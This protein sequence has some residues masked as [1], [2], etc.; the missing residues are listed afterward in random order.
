MQG[1]L[2]S[3]LLAS[4][5]LS[6][7][8]E[9][10]LLLFYIVFEKRRVKDQLLYIVLA[11]VFSF[12]S[13]TVCFAENISE[14]TGIPIKLF[15]LTVA[16]E[17]LS[18][19]QSDLQSA[20]T[21][22]SRAGFGFI[23]AETIVSVFLAFKGGTR[24]LKLLRIL[25]FVNNVVYIPIFL[26][27][28]ALFFVTTLLFLIEAAM[29][30][31]VPLCLIGTACLLPFRRARKVGLVCLGFLLVFGY[32]LPYCV[33]SALVKAPRVP[34]LDY[35]EDWGVVLF[36]VV[37]ES[38]DPVPYAL[39][40]LEF[41][42]PK[43]ESGMFVV[44]MNEYGKRLAILPH[45]VY[46]VKSVI[47]LW[48]NISDYSVSYCRGVALANYS[49]GSK[50][51]P[52]YGKLGEFSLEKGGYS[53]GVYSYKGDL[54]EVKITLRDFDWLVNETGVY[55]FSKAFVDHSEV[56]PL[57]LGDRILYK[58]VLEPGENMTVFFFGGRV[59]VRYEA[60]NPNMSVVYRT[61]LSDSVFNCSIVGENFFKFLY[62]EFSKWWNR[63][64]LDFIMR[65]CRNFSDFQDIAEFLNE[66][67]PRYF[68]YSPP[69]GVCKIWVGVHGNISRGDYCTVWVEVKPFKQWNYTT[70]Y[71]YN[72]YWS[73]YEGAYE[74]ERGFIGMIA[75]VFNLVKTMFYD[76]IW[77]S[78]AVFG[79]L[80]IGVAFDVLS[81]VFLSFPFFR[82]SGVSSS[83][84]RVG[85]RAFRF[86]KKKFFSK[87][88]REL[89]YLSKKMYG[90]KYS[91][92]PLKYRYLVL[93]KY[94][95]LKTGRRSLVK[96]VAFATVYGSEVLRYRSRVGLYRIVA[97]LAKSRRLERIVDELEKYPWGVRE[98]LLEKIG[99]KLRDVYDRARVEVAVRRLLKNPSARVSLDRRLVLLAQASL[100]LPRLIEVYGRYLRREVDDGEVLRVA[101][102]MVLSGEELARGCLRDPRA[103][104]LAVSAL[105]SF[106]V[107]SD[108]IERLPFMLDEKKIGLSEAREYALSFLNQVAFSRYLKTGRFEYDE[109]YRLEGRE[110]VE[111]VAE[112]AR[113]ESVD[114]R[115]WRSV[116]FSGIVEEFSKLGLEPREFYKLY[117]VTYRTGSWD[118]AVKV[119]QYVLWSCGLKDI[120][121]SK[122][123]VLYLSA[124]LSKP[125]EPSDVLEKEDFDTALAFVNEVVSADYLLQGYSPYEY[126]YGLPPEKFVEE[127]C[128]LAR[129]MLEESE[130]RKSVLDEALLEYLAQVEE[131]VYEYLE[132][133]K[134]VNR[135]DSLRNALAEVRELI[136][137]LEDLVK[138]HRELEEALGYYRELAQK[139]EKE[140]KE[141]E[142]D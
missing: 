75:G 57:V 113:R 78:L 51:F 116:L 99:E 133:A 62:S 13:F 41:N 137:V 124:L 28:K 120:D 27:G 82:V 32:I 34:K 102:L 52:V 23:V 65:A 54:V 123:A 101:A 131:R 136:A 115:V 81:T 4:A 30:F 26:L 94:F 38:G 132:E 90:R 122:E 66:S 3:L 15:S 58:V 91:S 88:R 64:R 21:G 135:E 106:P 103:A 6:I 56:S 126:I 12:I 48:I 125:V 47:V 68:Y 10:F 129:S 7:A 42:C 69:M 97:K 40:V 9:V 118:S 37:D 50:C 25:S 55:C 45:G 141:L 67:K 46:C 117:Y 8:I 98:K 53:D 74:T 35:P 121:A 2:R 5:S 83:F 140:L 77:S 138:E 87:Y 73:F 89:G 76:F 36:K 110:F 19:L 105:S 127:A 11:L 93:S 104:A 85:W 71:F 31:I 134:G 139:I 63:T 14:R 80:S 100:K 17:S 108:F 20:L 43:N 18:G 24:A 39:I 72:H 16:N 22:S 84:R 96:V 130:G 44:Q 114:E 61:R 128:F 107:K 49:L 95:Y 33:N 60:T 59:K 86:G 111:R 109:V 142:E 119:A 70:W 29:M 1:S 112:V 79:I 92:L